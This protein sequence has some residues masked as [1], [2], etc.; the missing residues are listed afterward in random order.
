MS[1]GIRIT[2]GAEFGGVEL[3][4]D[5]RRI[6]RVMQAARRSL[7]GLVGEPNREW[8]GWR[9]S[10]PDSR[11]VIGRSPRFENLFFAFGHGHLGLTLSAVT[12]ELL[13]VL[14]AG[15]EPDIDVTPFRPDRF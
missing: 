13:G 3:P 11:P 15:G 14:I 12:S 6:R 10:M 2:S 7:P 5:F 8:M 9:P 4:P 1:D